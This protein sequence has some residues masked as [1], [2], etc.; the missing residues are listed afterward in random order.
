M[1]HKHYISLPDVKGATSASRKI[2]VKHLVFL[3]TIFGF[4][5][6]RNQRSGKANYCGR[7]IQ[8]SGLRTKQILF[9]ENLAILRT[10]L[11]IDVVLCDSRW[12]VGTLV[13]W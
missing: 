12:H 9:I 4:P 3:V 2:Y 7:S 11:P 6:G 1:E 10:D 8:R 13:R 5:H